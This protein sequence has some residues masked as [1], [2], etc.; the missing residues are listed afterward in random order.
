MNVKGVAA[1]AL[2]ALAVL[3]TAVSATAAFAT[4][5][6]IRGTSTPIAVRLAAPIDIASGAFV[7]QYVRAGFACNTG[8]VMVG[9]HINQQKVT[10][11]RLNY[12][13]RIANTIV[14]P[15]HGTQVPPF[16]N[17][18]MHGC[19]PNYVVQSLQHVGVFD[20]IL[21]CVSLENNIGQALLLPNAYVD[22]PGPTDN[23]T[24]STI[25]GLNSPIMHVCEPDY[26]M[27]GIHQANNDLYCAG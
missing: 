10:C 22:G 5:G 23:G 25:Y 2:F 27:A 8:E 4:V 3:V 21:T 17:P 24:Q 13:Y 1:S 6:P 14:D 19:P 7:Q 9:I 15:V 26:A 12:G 20:E 16:D 11:A 18:Y